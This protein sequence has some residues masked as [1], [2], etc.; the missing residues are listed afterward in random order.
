M[1]AVPASLEGYLATLEGHAAAS[2]NPAAYWH[3]AGLCLVIWK[4]GGIPAPEWDPHVNRNLMPL[5]AALRRFG[6]SLVDAVNARAFA[7]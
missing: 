4:S 1:P 7:A 5:F 3:C 6:R 2:G